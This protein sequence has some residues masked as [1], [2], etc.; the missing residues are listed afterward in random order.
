M[1]LKNFRAYSD[2]ELTLKPGINLLIGPNATGKTTILEALSVALG[3]IFLGIR[4]YDSLTIR[5]EDTRIK[6]NTTG[7]SLSIERQYPVEVRTRGLVFDHEVEW[8]RT[9]F[10]ALS[11]PANRTS[12]KEALELQKLAKESRGPWLPCV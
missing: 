6:A 3:S 1:K 12:R 5:P 7:E 2:F 4:G 11:G 10:S 8:A 9:L